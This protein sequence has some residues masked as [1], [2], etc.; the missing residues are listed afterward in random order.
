[1][2]GLP[3]EDILRAAEA[4]GAS[5]VRVFGSRARGDAR[6]DSDLDLLLTLPRGTTLFDLARLKRTLEE[7]LGIRVD[8]LTE[9]SLHPLLKERILAEAR[10][11]IAA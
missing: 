4:L 9:G 1:M 6:P 11:L 10:P 2:D 3:I 7:R 8:L 5:N